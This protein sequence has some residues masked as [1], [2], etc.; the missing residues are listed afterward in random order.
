MV[1][2][3][4]GRRHYLRNIYKATLKEIN[5]S[6]LYAA[7]FWNIKKKKRELRVAFPNLAALF[8]D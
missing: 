5:V 8:R 6:S 2:S 7:F 3:L 1:Y 4:I